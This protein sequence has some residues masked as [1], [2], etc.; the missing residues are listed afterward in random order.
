VLLL[1]ATLCPAQE[2][3][4]YDG[5]YASD[6]HCG[7]FMDSLPAKMR[8]SAR[9][10]S[11]RLGLPPSNAGNMVLEL[12]DRPLG[13]KKEVQLGGTV[14]KVVNGKTEQ[15]ITLNPESHFAPG[16]DFDIELDHEMTHALLRNALGDAPHRLLPKWAREG[17]AVWAAGQGPGR[18]A[19]WLTIYW[20]KPDPVKSLLNGLEAEKHSLEDYAEDYLAVAAIESLHGVA[21]V[22][23]FVKD[24]AAGKPCRDAAA[25]ASGKSWAEFE[26]FAHAFAEARIGEALGQSEWALWKRTMTVYR[27]GRDWPAAQRALYAITVRYPDSWAGA[28][29]TYYFGRALQ[30]AGRPED[31]RKALA[32]F[33]VVAGPRTGLMDDAVWNIGLCCEKSGDVEGA[34]TAFD[35]LAK[36]YSYSPQAAAGLLKA[37][38]LCA[39]AGRNDEAKARWERIAKDLEGT[40]EAAEARKHLGLQ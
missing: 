16:G 4:S 34:I 17:L 37:A 22:Q 24:L 32:E 5:K 30:Q 35:R 39:G 11:G 31:A 28:L 20:D 10:M 8:A 26:L 7:A 29:A 3:R 14:T 27:S 36:E 21:G 25:A 15:W 33:L 12:V 9:E 19:F 2:I 1:T 40:K 38:E 6:P 23:A 13:A 18:I